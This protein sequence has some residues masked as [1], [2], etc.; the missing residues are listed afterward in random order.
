MSLFIL[1]SEEERG[2]AKML[3]VLGADEQTSWDDLLQAGARLSKAIGGGWSLY[4][5]QPPD[6]QRLIMLTEAVQEQLEEKGEAVLDLD[7]KMVTIAELQ[8]VATGLGLEVG[9]VAVLKRRS[10]QPPP[11]VAPFDREL[12]A[13]EKMAEYIDGRLPGYRRIMIDEHLCD[14]VAC[15]GVYLSVLRF[16]LE[17]EEEF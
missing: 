4:Q 9:L 14:C 15:F 12:I 6:D 2:L 8:A 16:Q 13:A 7:V 5:I 3:P 17:G 10:G 11:V 1:I